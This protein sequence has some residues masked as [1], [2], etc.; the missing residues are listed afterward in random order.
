ML[1]RFVFGSSW[2][3]D[4]L[5]RCVG[6]VLVDRCD[7]R[8]LVADEAHFVERERV[9][10]RRPRNDAVLDRHVLARDDRVHT[11]QRERF[12][13][14]H[15]LH[16][17]VSVRR[18]QRL[19]VQHSGQHDVVRIH[20]STGGFG[21]SVDLAVRLADDLKSLV[22]KRSRRFVAPGCTGAVLVACTHGRCSLERASASFCAASLACFC[23]S[24]ALMRC[25][26]HERGAGATPIDSA[27]ASSTASKICV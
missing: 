27:T 11:R 15:P 1:P 4:Q 16:Q 26:S 12:R 5:Q 19:R 2:I 23:A 22:F 8:D 9:L 13:S 10:V 21:E 25:A 18:A 14:V 17:C 3:G 6:R 24:S 20:R 7:R